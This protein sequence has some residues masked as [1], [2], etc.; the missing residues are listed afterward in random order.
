MFFTTEDYKRIQQ[1]LQHNSMKDTDLPDTGEMKGNETLVIVQNGRNVRV[2]LSEFVDQLFLVGTPDFVNATDKFGA[3]S[4]EE[5]MKAIPYR[6]RKA[7]QMVTFIT[8]D[9]DWKVYQF[10]GQRV[11]QWNTKSLWVEL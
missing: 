10:R 9:G 3:H 7:G 11:N 1:W 8:E 6:A 2:T 4:I 5:V